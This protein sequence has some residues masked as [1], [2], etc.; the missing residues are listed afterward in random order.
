M[1]LQGI[2]VSAVWPAY[3]FY[4]L[5]AHGA[6]RYKARVC[7][8]PPPLAGVGGAAGNVESQLSPDGVGT[9]ATT[10]ASS[11][12]G[13]TAGITVTEPDTS[14]MQKQSAGLATLAFILFTCKA[15]VCCK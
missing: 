10:E 2:N 5:A 6:S 15:K 13:G 1:K 8:I 11:T 7:N 3:N 12:N 14:T 4:C 9:A